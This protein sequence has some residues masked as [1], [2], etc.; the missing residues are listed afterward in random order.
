ML[1]QDEVDGTVF[2]RGSCTTASTIQIAALRQLIKNAAPVAPLV[3]SVFF[4]LPEQVYVY[5]DCAMRQ[6]TDCGAW[7]NRDSICGFRHCLRH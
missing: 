5:G 3:S 7:R 4:M 2:R 6:Q 1:E